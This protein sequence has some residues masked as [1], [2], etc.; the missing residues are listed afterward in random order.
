V[1]TDTT[2]PDFRQHT[3]TVPDSP[4]PGLSQLGI[5]VDEHGR[6]HDARNGH[7]MK[8]SVANVRTLAGWQDFILDYGEPVGTPAHAAVTEAEV[9]HEPESLRNWAKRK[10]RWAS[11]EVQLLPATTL[12]FAGKGLMKVFEWAKRSPRR[13]WVGGAVGAFALAAIAGEA[14]ASAKYG[15]GSGAKHEV[16]NDLIMQQHR[17]TP[18]GS[19]HHEVVSSLTFHS[20]TNGEQDVLQQLHTTGSTSAHQEVLHEL[21]LHPGS[22]AKREVLSELRFPSHTPPLPPHHPHHHDL[23]D[24]FP[25]RVFIEHG[26]SYTR[27]LQQLAARKGITLSDAD[28]FRLEEYLKTPTGVHMF[29]DDPSYVIQTGK[30]AGEWGISSP[31]LEP[32]NP[33]IEPRINHWLEING[34]LSK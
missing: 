9:A 3:E 32:L 11:N 28:S 33:H 22:S 7:F 34:F 31:G 30:Y 15:G 4:Q 26:S 13:A 12:E 14:M 19:A 23:V 24:G 16:L 8:L 2:P 5:T 21:Q 1:I 17:N 29:Q 6:A 27:E 10:V 20:G 18:T 25:R